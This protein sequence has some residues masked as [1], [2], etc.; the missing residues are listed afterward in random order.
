MIAGY[1]LSS[2]GDLSSHKLDTEI[3]VLNAT[4]IKVW[5]NFEI[6]FQSLKV[7]L[8]RALLLWNIDDRR[9]TY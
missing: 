7:A 2:V 3:T 1:L 6:H 4:F 9:C 5:T 8:L